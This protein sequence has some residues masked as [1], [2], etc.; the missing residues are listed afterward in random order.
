MVEGERTTHEPCLRAR[1]SPYGGDTETCSRVQDS[2]AVRPE[3][4]LSW[5]TGS[6]P[7]WF[8][9]SKRI[10]MAR[11]KEAGDVEIPVASAWG[12][13]AGDVGKMKNC[14]VHHRTLYA[15]PG[16]HW[17]CLGN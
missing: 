2:G 13:E 14:K 15:G 9:Q 17:S 5:L 10:D 1:I 7:Q 12:R 8:H 11:R 16:W 4:V 6:I 3:W